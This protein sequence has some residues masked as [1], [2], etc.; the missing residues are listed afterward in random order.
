MTI[1]CPY[2]ISANTKM[3]TPKTCTIC[4]ETEPMVRFRH[5]KRVCVSCRNKRVYVSRKRKRI[6]DAEEYGVN[7]IQPP[8]NLWK[9]GERDHKEQSALSF[10][11]EYDLRFVKD[12]GAIDDAAWEE[13]LEYKYKNRIRP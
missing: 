12:N 2:F 13:W 1:N 3:Q 6:L 11:L 4:K 9:P 5:G 7:A 10:A 8:K